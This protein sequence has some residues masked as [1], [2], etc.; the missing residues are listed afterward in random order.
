MLQN[1]RPST[2]QAT[3]IS[4]D[5]RTATHSGVSDLL[6]F[7]PCTMIARLQTCHGHD[8]TLGLKWFSA[9]AEVSQRVQQ[10]LLKGSK[11]PSQGLLGMQNP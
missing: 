4:E 11:F 7:T 1:G 3:V 9:H 8:I 6:A 5:L 10:Q 2:Q